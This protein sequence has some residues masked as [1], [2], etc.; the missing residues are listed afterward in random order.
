MYNRF[1]RGE[2]I[3]WVS[4]G[5]GALD[6]PGPKWH[7]LRSCHL[8]ARLGQSSPAS[9]AGASVLGRF[10]SF[11]HH[12]VGILLHL[13]E[14]GANVLRVRR[15]IQYVTGNYLK[16]GKYKDDLSYTPLRYSLKGLCHEMYIVFK[17]YKI[18]SVFFI[19]ALIVFKR[20]CKD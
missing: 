7:S 10:S 3:T 13:C 19:C 1:H 9:Q 15:R 5:E 2:W 18:K 8:R 12:W 20:V 14:S 4:G 11:R 17:N 6:T 16:N